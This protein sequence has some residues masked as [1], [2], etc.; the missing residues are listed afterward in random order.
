MCCFI[1]QEQQQQPQQVGLD[2]VRLLAQQ[3]AVSLDRLWLKLRPV[4]WEELTQRPL[5]LQQLL[6]LARLG[7][8]LYIVA[9]LSEMASLVRDCLLVSITFIVLTPKSVRLATS[10]LFT[11]A[12]MVLISNVR[13][14]TLDC[15]EIVSFSEL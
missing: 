2:L 5:P 15:T 8:C 11:K 1:S 12:P 14:V 4:A 7:N 6:T 10:F 3:E 9:F 13:V